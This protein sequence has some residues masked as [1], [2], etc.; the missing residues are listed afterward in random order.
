MIKAYRALALVLL[1]S[2]AALFAAACAA[3]EKN[4]PGAENYGEQT[5]FVAEVRWVPLEGGFFGLVTE[6]GRKF[7]PLNLPADFRS[8]GLKVKVEGRT[9]D[10]I[11]IYMWGRPFEISNIELYGP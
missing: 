2:A 1:M 9:K 6:D 4:S 11:T 8:D 10:V 3:P 7:L 5:G